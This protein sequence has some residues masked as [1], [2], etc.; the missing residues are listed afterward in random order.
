MR[1]PTRKLAVRRET[2]RALENT[3]LVAVA[4]GA[5]VAGDTGGKGCYAV[6]DMSAQPPPG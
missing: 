4:G 1:K 2:L 3:E 5:V 6:A